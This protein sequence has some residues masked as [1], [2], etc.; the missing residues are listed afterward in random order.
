MIF[1]TK[2]LSSMEKVFCDRELDAKELRE[3][4]VCRGETA[5]FQ[6][7]YRGDVYA[8]FVKIKIESDCQLPISVRTVGYVPCDFL[9]P[10]FDENV[11]SKTAGLFPDPLL[12]FDGK[13]NILP[14][15]WRALWLT[16]Q[17]PENINAGNYIVR[18]SFSYNQAH[19][20]LES[21]AEFNLRV[22]NALIPKQTLI[23]TE[24][25]HADC[26]ASYYKTDSWSEK[27]WSLIRE[28][29]TNAAQHGINTI[30]TPLWTAPLDTAVGHERPTTQLLVIKETDGKYDF[31]FSNLARWIDI[32]SESGIE[33]FEM[34]HFFTQWG[35][36]FTPK[37]VVLKDGHEVKRFGWH[38]PAL[39]LD[40]KAFLTQ[41]IPKLL[42][43][44]ESKK[45]RGK[46]YFH[47]SDEPHINMIDEYALASATIKELVGDY[48]IIDA[49]S[50]IE[51]YAKG[52]ILN[53]VPAL[54]HVE[55]FLNAKLENLWIYYCS[56]Q[57]N[58][59]SNRFFHFSS[60]RNRI[61]G[62][63][64]FKYAI[65]GFL[66]WGYNFWYGQYSQDQELNPFLTTDAGQAFA[67]GDSFIVYPGKNGPIDSIRHEVFRDAL[68][69]IGALRLLEAKIGREKTISY[70][71]EGLA[72]PLSFHE[73]PSD[74]NWILNMREKVNMRIQ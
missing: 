46:V 36:K 15:Q 19:L 66:H 9:G 16:V 23:R 5:S 42:E 3:Q 38:L 32:C 4:S 7:A 33:N 41:L 54:D 57:W 63:L 1:E 43:F 50:N 10:N 21:S 65:K 61:I 55:P 67:G 53:P 29:A 49:L 30:L 72:V 68:Q 25:F 28:Y 69:D 35:A 44:F 74:P 20:T 59:V 39:S 8:K 47:V 40:Y 56:G 73:Y 58:K 14:G 51:F 48:P 34:S 12:P 22:I 64:M 37:I 24:W 17:V 6:L 27:H 31:D 70:I 13:L 71:E 11:L 62:V 52:I 26:I 2:F 60:A 18:V 45:L